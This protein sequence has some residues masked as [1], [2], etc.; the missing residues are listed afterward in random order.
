MKPQASD[1]DTVF[2][3][4]VSY[5]GLVSRIYKGYQLNDF[6]YMTF[7]K[8]QNFRGEKTNQWLPG[9][10]T[11]ETVWLQMDMREGL[12]V[13]GTFYLMVVMEVIGLHEFVKTHETVHQK[14]WIFTVCK[15]YLHPKGT[16]EAV[17]PSGWQAWSWDH[18]L[19]AT[20]TRGCTRGPWGIRQDSSGGRLAKTWSDPQGS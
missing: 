12:G 7:W 9:A 17:L 2:A 3:K 20:P 14:R 13:V 11:G 15:A 5:K 16:R 18:R 8:S 4:H 6:I 1:W 19:W 10:G